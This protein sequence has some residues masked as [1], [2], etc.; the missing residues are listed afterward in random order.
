MVCYNDYQAV[1]LIRAARQ[2]NVPLP[3]RLSIVGYGDTELAR[4]TDPT[5]TTLRIPAFEIGCETARMLLE[6][7]EGR[8]VESVAVPCEMVAR[9]SAVGR[10]V[11]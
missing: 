1:G 9:E 7:I 4:I 6:R 2:Q 8:T 11:V 3:Q 5:L 10:Q